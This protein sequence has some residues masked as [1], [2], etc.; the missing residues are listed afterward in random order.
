MKNAILHSLF[1]ILRLFS[2]RRRRRLANGDIPRHCPFQPVGQRHGRLETEQLPRPRHIQATPRL[3]VRPRGIETHF[4]VEAGLARDQFRQ[5]GD[6]NFAAGADVDRIGR[7]Q[8]LGGADHG[9]RCVF[10]VE[11]LARRLAGAPDRQHAVAAILGLD[12]LADQGGDDMRT[13]QIEIVARAVK[14]DHE[15]VD[16]VEAVFWR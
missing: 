11:K 13:F 12:A 8:D 3:A 6:G 9:P 14:V 2:R 4:A 10:D 16:A 1:F 15:Q 7:F 5:L